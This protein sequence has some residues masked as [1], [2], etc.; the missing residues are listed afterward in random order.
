MNIS[1]IVG[2]YLCYQVE[3]SLMSSLWYIILKMFA[4][5]KSLKERPSRVE[6]IFPSRVLK[7]MN[8]LIKWVE[9]LGEV[10]RSTGN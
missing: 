4:S 5:I 9:D 6:G 7:A 3:D 2:F 1:I 10:S 8:G